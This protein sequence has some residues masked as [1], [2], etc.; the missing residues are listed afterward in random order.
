ML[1]GSISPPFLE[2]D[3][4][5]LPCAT[6]GIQLTLSLLLSEFP[7]AG[8]ARGKELFLFPR[9]PRAQDSLPSCAFKVRPSRSNRVRARAHSPFSRTPSGK[10]PGKWGTR[11]SVGSTPG[12]LWKL[13]QTLPCDSV[14]PSLQQQHS[15]SLPHLSPWKHRE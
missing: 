15:H 13:E 10:K 6:P 11:F 9:H 5:C 1:P 3:L 4:S 12:Q 14:S 8:R 7:L 2:P